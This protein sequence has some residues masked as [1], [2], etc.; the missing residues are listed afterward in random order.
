[1][2]AVK[3]TSEETLAEMEARLENTL[4]PIAPSSGFVTTLRKRVTMPSREI[5]V[6]KFG[7][8]PQLF[9][10]FASVMSAS[11]VI[12]TVAR[13]LYFFFYRKSTA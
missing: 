7:S 3:R 1:M 2:C 5:M 8:Y 6:E 12:L 9:L 11:L 13:A 4:Q 10:A